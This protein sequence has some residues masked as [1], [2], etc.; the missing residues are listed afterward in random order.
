MMSL[1]WWVVN[2]FLLTIW[3]FYLNFFSAHSL[4]PLLPNVYGTCW[5]LALSPSS[6]RELN[7]KSIHLHTDIIRFS[8]TMTLWITFPNDSGKRT[9]STCEALLSFIV[10]QQNNFFIFSV[11]RWTIKAS[12]SKHRPTVARFLCKKYIDCKTGRQKTSRWKSFR[13]SLWRVWLSEKRV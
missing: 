10:K 7:T 12:A 13:K 8:I 2:I 5:N 11:M 1:Q 3:N 4:F 6:R 9:H